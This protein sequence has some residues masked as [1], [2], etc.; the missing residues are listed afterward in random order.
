M[1]AAPKSARRTIARTSKANETWLGQM[2][3]MRR[4]QLDKQKEHVQP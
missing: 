2:S 4:C 3:T 1:R